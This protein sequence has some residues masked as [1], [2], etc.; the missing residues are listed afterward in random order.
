MA[1]LVALG[2]RAVAGCA[3]GATVWDGGGAESTGVCVGYL[4]ARE[5]VWALPGLAA[6]LGLWGPDFGVRWGRGLGQRSL[7]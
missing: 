7:S 6:S 1:R 2:E 5:G 3:L 4:L